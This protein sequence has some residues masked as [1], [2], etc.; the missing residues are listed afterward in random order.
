MATA[1]TDIVRAIEEIASKVKG[2]VQYM[3]QL[4]LNTDDHFRGMIV[5]RE[6]ITNPDAAYS[7]IR[8]DIVLVI[9]DKGIH[10]LV[11][12]KSS[13]AITWYHGLGQYAHLSPTAVKALGADFALFNINSIRE[14]IKRKLIDRAIKLRHH[15]KS[16]EQCAQ[17]I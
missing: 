3:G 11:E 17:L 6:K 15:A 14:T 5:T 16:L 9:S 13:N 10:I 8:N 4:H 7:G 1:P 12:V 2:I